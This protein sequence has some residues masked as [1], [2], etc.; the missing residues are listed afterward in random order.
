MTCSAS[1]L[2]APPKQLKAGLFIVIIV[3][4]CNA[5][6]LFEKTYFMFRSC[7]DCHYIPDHARPR[8]CSLPDRPYNPRAS[9]DLYRLRSFSITSK[10]SVVN[11]GDSIISRRSRSNT[12]VNSTASSN[13]ASDRSPFDNCCGA[14]YLAVGSI[15]QSTSEPSSPGEP[16]PNPKYRVVML[17]DSGVG[18]TALVSQFMTSEY[19]NTYDASLDEEF[20]E[21]TVSVLL[22]GE[23]S[24]MTF[25]DHPAVE[26]SVENSLSTYEP[27]ACVVV[28]SV[29]AK[30]SFQFAEETLNYLWQE[31]ITKDKS[32][33]VVANK[34]DLARARVI[35]NAD[36]KT[37][38]A[39]REC[40]FI[41]TSSGIQ[42][43]VDELLV[44]ILKQV[45]LKESRDKKRQQQESTSSNGSN[46]KLK[47]SRTHVSLHLAREL[48]QK[49][50]I[51]DIT[52][53]RSCENLHVL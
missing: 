17:G 11:C 15:S 16:P 29:V 24:E 3:I 49:I 50:C 39:S 9:D 14:G 27:H 20:G 21:K 31:N 52:K 30:H 42:H 46:G 33:I 28:Y 1:A 4:V 25:I 13:R 18:K 38:A 36:G 41:E 43:N 37:L 40:K 45:R 26:M 6:N 53:S 12:S 2:V 7:D 47:N 44:G 5:V 34:A 32:V 19:M 8:V 23:E 35:P 10:G 48:L 51:N 22:D